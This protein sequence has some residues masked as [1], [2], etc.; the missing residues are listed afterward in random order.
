MAL[1][2]QRLSQEVPKNVRGLC[3]RLHEAGHR[4][5]IVGGCVR[6]ELLLDLPVP[7]GVEPRAAVSTRNDW[8]IA[9]SAHPEQV[10]KLF[11]RVI[12]TGLQHGTV[13]VLMGKEQY[14][15]TTLRGETTYSDARRPD[16][17][18]FVDDIRDDLAR[19]DFTINAI[20]YDVLEDRL[21]DPFGGIQ[22][23]VARRLKAV[24]DPNERFAED[25]LRVLRAARFVALLELELETE[26]ARAIRPS[27]DSYRKVSAERVRDEWLK[28]MKAA[29]PSLAFEVMRQHGLLEITAPEL[30]ESVGCEQNRYHAYDVWGHALAC[31]DLSPRHPVLRVAGLLHD[32][33]K[34]RTR[35]FSEKTKDYTFYEH[36]R[37]GAEMVA[38]LL[39][40]LRFSNQERDHITALVR[41]HLICYD[42]AWSDAAVRRWLRRIGP[43]LLPDLY[44]LAEADVRGKGRDVTSDLQNIE[45]LKA[46]VARILAAGAA[47]NV[48]DLAISGRDLGKIGLK[49]GPLY[50][51][52][53]RR[54]LD[55]V[56]EQPELNRAE[57]LLDRARQI[58]DELA[59]S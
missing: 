29:R 11:S 30:L 37:V 20:A 5:W 45:A 7:S 19:R 16:S 9:T 22:D 13:T 36:E 31:L 46:H 33:G 35:A 42:R 1:S 3:Q 54:L 34:P 52:I 59:A 51:E 55:E 40:R 23:L 2:T 53:L 48:R 44:H 39:E 6:D 28:T 26:T 38:P 24:R 43:E 17:V 25:G 58:S 57:L 41:N 50:G 12:P 49:P 47:L 32:I 4:S 18:Y 8:D 56:V 27:L 21:I 10:M 15:V 14:E